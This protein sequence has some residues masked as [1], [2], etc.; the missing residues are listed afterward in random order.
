MSDQESER[1]RPHPT[2]RFAA[3]QHQYDLEEVASKL[4]QEINAGEA[5]HRQET[6]Y[7]RGG[8]TV[9]LFVFE[10]LSHLPPHRAKGVVTI[11]VLKGHL[12]IIAEDQ[13][14]DLHSSNLLV[15]AP[16]VQ[17]DVVARQE[18]WMLL[19]VNLDGNPNS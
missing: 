13:T 18:T 19:T 14:H 16:G 11:H 5:G 12:Q 15:L 1:L 6:L 9:S 17:H 2:V 8:V 7:K 10:H 4:K 3:P